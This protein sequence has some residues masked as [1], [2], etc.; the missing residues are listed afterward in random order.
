MNRN[1]QLAQIQRWWERIA[2]SRRRQLRV[3][4]R[5][6]T[7]GAAGTACLAWPSPSLHLRAVD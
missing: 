3:V 6:R 2:A 7:T 4:R 1:R 5:D